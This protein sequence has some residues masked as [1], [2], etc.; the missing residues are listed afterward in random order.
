MPESF[1]LVRHTTTLKTTMTFHSFKFIIFVKILTLLFDNTTFVA[2][3]QQKISQ[4]NK[5][6]AICFSNTTITLT[7]HAPIWKRQGLCTHPP[8][9]TLSTS[10]FLN[11]Q[12]SLSQVVEHKHH[13][14]NSQTVCLNSTNLH[15]KSY[16]TH[17]GSDSP[18]FVSVSSQL[19]L[20]RLESS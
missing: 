19:G 18:P 12:F 14:R 15:Q 9:Q 11:W 5:H 20:E 1:N 2:L 3:K 16:L 10:L 7:H 4:F 13:Q 17:C 8:H 6:C